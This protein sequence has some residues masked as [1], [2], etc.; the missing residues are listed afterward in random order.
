MPPSHNYKRRYVV[1]QHSPDDQTLQLQ[2]GAG[3]DD[4]IH[5]PS[6]LNRV[7][8]LRQEEEEGDFMKELQRHP[9]ENAHANFCV[10]EE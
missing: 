3:E 9:F 7:D 6:G 2:A 1:C 10:I 4:A 5:L 8:C